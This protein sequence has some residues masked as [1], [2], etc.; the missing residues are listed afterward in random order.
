MKDYKKTFILL[1]S[2]IVIIF[3]MCAMAF[4]EEE[5]GG[6]LEE[7][8]KIVEEMNSIIDDQDINDEEKI[9][10]LKELEVKLN[11]TVKQYGN[12]LDIELKPRLVFDKASHVANGASLRNRTSCTIALRG[13][14]KKS[15]ILQALL[16]FNLGAAL[17]RRPMLPGFYSS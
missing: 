9:E 2:A 13:V 14:P 4:A 5:N 16:Y 12:E 15:K 11:D 8:R 7:A 17:L 3:F 10:L 6:G 1:T